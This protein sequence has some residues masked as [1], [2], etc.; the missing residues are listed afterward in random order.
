MPCCNVYFIG[1]VMLN[2]FHKIGDNTAPNVYAV[3]SGRSIFSDLST[4]VFSGLDG[5]NPIFQQYAR[6]GY[7]TQVS[8][9]FTPNPVSRLTFIFI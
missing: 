8:E 6:E 3:L 7:A 5:M 9:D 4:L 1:A 2:G